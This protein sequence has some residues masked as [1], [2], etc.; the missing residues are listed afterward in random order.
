MS[1]P[2]EAFG[3]SS[4]IDRNYYSVTVECL[5]PTYLHKIERVEFDKL[6][7]KYPERSGTFYKKV[8]GMIG[9]RLVECYRQM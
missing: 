9:H 3:W 4:L 1:H 8:A 5:T 7:Q 6:L 2:G